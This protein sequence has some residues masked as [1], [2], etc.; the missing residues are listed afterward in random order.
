[1]NFYELLVHIFPR[2]IGFKVTW[3]NVWSNRNRNRQQNKI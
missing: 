3:E 1:M 2:Y